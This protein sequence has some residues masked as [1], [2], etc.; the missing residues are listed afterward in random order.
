MLETEYG[1]E[2]ERFLRGTVLDIPKTFMSFPTRNLTRFSILGPK[3]ILCCSRDREE[4]E[5]L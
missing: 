3:K 4:E 2:K 1:I 5:L